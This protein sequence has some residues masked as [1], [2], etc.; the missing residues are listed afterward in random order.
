M[1]VHPRFNIEGNLAFDNSN[2]GK[3]HIRSNCCLE[4]KTMSNY[5]GSSIKVFCAGYQRLLKDSQVAL[6]DWNKVRTD[7]HSAGRREKAADNL[8][9]TLQAKFAKAWASLECH[10][11]TCQVCQI[12]STHRSRFERSPEVRRPEANSELTQLASTRR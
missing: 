7:I 4:V 6:A 2:E 8:L 9:R 5:S 11:Q 10:E 1:E 3:N 12:K